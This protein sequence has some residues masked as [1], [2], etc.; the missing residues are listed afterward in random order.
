MVLNYQHY[1]FYISGIAVIA[2]DSMYLVIRLK[3][4]K[5]THIRTSYFWI[6][7]FIEDFTKF[8]LQD[9]II[10][11]FLFF[12][13]PCPEWSP[14]I[15]NPWAMRLKRGS[16]RKNIETIIQICAIFF[17]RQ[18]QKTRIWPELDWLIGPETLLENLC[19]TSV[20]PF[21]HT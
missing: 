19:K 10:S 17:F 2:R 21:L 16:K 4:G 1:N 12:T 13:F 14:K 15:R 3:K 18:A 5:K 7:V 8:L 6:Y 20:L 11:N 9:Y